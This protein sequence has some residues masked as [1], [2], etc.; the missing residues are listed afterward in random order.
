M[1]RE[2][3][4]GSHDR[5][6]ST[7]QACRVLVPARVLCDGCPQEAFERGLL[8]ASHAIAVDGGSTDP[9]PF[10]PVVSNN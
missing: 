9:A 10:Y 1:S 4:K 8:L 5:L 2:A 7:T 6:Y 3:V